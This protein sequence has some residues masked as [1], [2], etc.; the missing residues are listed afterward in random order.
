MSSNTKKA[1]V[2]AEL[3]LLGALSLHN[4]SRQGVTAA[5]GPEPLRPAFALQGDYRELE[6]PQP[7]FSKAV[8]LL[9]RS[10]EF[11]LIAALRQDQANSGTIMSFSHGFNRYLELQSSGRRDE[12]RLHY[13][14]AGSESARVETFPYRLADGT[15]H[16]VAL[17]VSGTQV[18]LLVDCHPLYRRSISPPDRNFTQPQLS[19]WLGQRNSKHSLFKGAF[20]DVRLISG[21]HGYLTQCPGLDS[22]CPTC[23]Q[24]SLLQATV[25]E[26]TSHIHEISKKLIEH[27]ERLRIKEECDCQKSCFVNGTIHADGATWQKD[28]NKCACVHGE[29][30]CR[31][32]ECAPALCRNPVLHPGDCC[33][34]CLK[35]CFLKGVLYEHGELVSPKQC[36]ECECKDGNM[37]CSRIDP[38]NKCPQLP[39]KLSE[40]ISVSGECCKFCPGVDYCSLGHTCSENATCMN[41]ITEYSCNCNQG[42]KGDGITCEDIDECLSEGGLYGHHCH[43]HTRCTNIVGSYVCQCEDGY[44]RSDKFNCIEVDECASGDHRCSPFA[45]C[46]NTAGSYSCQCMQG[47]HGDGYDCKPICTGGCLNGGTCQSPDR[48][49][50]RPGFTGQHCERDLDECTTNTHHCPSTATCVNMPGW[51]YCKCKSGYRSLPLR[52]SQATACQDINEC[53]EELHTCHPSAKCV[54]TDGSFQ[55]ECTQPDCKLSCMH[56][57]QEIP[58]GNEWMK[59]CQICSCHKGVLS[60]SPAPCICPPR[61]PGT[62][63]RPSPSCCPQCNPSYDCHHQELHHVVFHSGERWVYQCQTCECLLGEVDCWE[64]ECPIGDNSMGEGM[65][66]SAANGITGTHIAEALC[67]PNSSTPCPQAAHHTAPDCQ[68]AYCATLVSNIACCVHRSAAMMVLVWVWWAAAAWRQIRQAIHRKHRGVREPP[69]L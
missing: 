57:S 33:P 4:S 1:E 40:Q 34:T 63:I 36:V 68:M 5:A 49:E 12:I 8:D 21:P 11:T 64:L 58:D 46:N 60:C 28:C 2:A 14:A 41:L 32:V 37:G 19:L 59:Q 25:Q 27:E 3:D 30:S 17:S 55:C 15:W 42:F 6:V 35:R 29:I 44:A 13:V 10:P 38:E 50:C 48:C 51:Y 65:C 16:R 20:Q 45:H 31:P 47:Y 9:R 22:E 67:S 53:A 66:C 62:G 61:P 18:Q 23:G 56:D 43:L 26:L 54:N 52:N 24:F 7:A 69:P 39:C